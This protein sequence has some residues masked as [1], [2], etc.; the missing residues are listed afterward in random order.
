M[1]LRKLQ[2]SNPEM[3]EPALAFIRNHLGHAKAKDFEKRLQRVQQRQQRAIAAPQNDLASQWDA[4]LAHRI[5]VAPRPTEAHQKQYPHWVRD[6]KRLQTKKFAKVFD[7]DTEAATWMTPLA[8]SFDRWARLSS[9]AMCKECK[10]LQ[11]RSFGPS[12]AAFNAADPA[13]E[14]TSAPKLAIALN[15]HVGTQ[16][17]AEKD[18][19][20]YP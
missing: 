16:R 3:V 14:R 17:R 5:V 8:Q 20:V 12:D 1:A 15:G 19:C 2:Q 11:K 6:D 4:A 13:E 18:Y 7:E 10:R 9:W